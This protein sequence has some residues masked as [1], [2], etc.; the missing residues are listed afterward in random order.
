M[1]ELVLAIGGCVVM[2]RI[3]DYEN[4]SAL[5]WGGVTALLC[6][7]GFFLPIPFLRTILALVAAFVLMIVAGIV[8]KK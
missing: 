3:A 1:F 7:G 2:G 6:I 8:S 4:R 5:T